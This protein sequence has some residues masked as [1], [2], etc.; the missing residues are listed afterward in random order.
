MVA[1]SLIYSGL[2][3]LLTL[4]R[5]FIWA[6]DYRRKTWLGITFRLETVKTVFDSQ[7]Q[8]QRYVYCTYRIVWL[9]AINAL[10]NHLTIL[11]IDN[12][13]S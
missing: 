12:N 2:K 10:V 9:D 5:F 1:H 13:D 3:V 8:D 4:D 11:T 7:G 6:R